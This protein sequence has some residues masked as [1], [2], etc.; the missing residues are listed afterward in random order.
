MKLKS[1]YLI[2]LLITGI[3]AWFL[4]LAREILAPFVLAAVFAYLLNPLVSILDQRLKIRRD[5]SIF[6]VYLVI[7]AVLIFAGG[8][9]GRKLVQ[10]TRDFAA[11]ARVNLTILERGEEI[12]NL[13]DWVAPYVPELIT[14]LRHSVSFSSQQAVK[15]FSGA[16]ESLAALFVFF[17]GLFYFLKD[18]QKFFGQIEKLFPGGSRI[19]FGIV[20]R[21]VNQILGNY[22]RAQSLLIGIM[23]IAN[24]VAFSLLG[25]K[26]SLIIGLVAG[27]AEIIPIVGPTAAFLF[28]LLVTIISGGLPNIG[29]Q[30]FYEIPLAGLIYLL[31]NQLENA[32]VVPQITG[33]MVAL[34]P[35]L[36]LLSVLIG[37]HL[38]G[39]LGFLVAVPLVA[40][41]KVILDHILD[42][43]E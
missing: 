15:V 5:L 18:G 14:S 32:L 22:L 28:I 35:V 29:L 36:V 23:F 43:A 7:F 27:L 3:S 2:Y 37:G 33:R 40:S 42:L 39:A 10:E 24:F 13:P 25:S 9:I 6:I 38:F 1:K 26:Y 8:V 34:H 11:E 20:I 21:K 41:V 12:A 4:Y 30:V 17:M 16:I 31:I 19:E